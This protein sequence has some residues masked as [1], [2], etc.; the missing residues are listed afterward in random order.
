MTL[1]TTKSTGKKKK[2]HKDK[3]GLVLYM[4]AHWYTCIAQWDHCIK[5]S[6]C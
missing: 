3:Y 2:K 4:F 5:H 6:H 1:C